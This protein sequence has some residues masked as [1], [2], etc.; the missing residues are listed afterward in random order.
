[1]DRDALTFLTQCGGRNAVARVF[2]AGFRTMDDIDK[3]RDLF[4]TLL[5]PA[6]AG[7]VLA[8]L[9]RQKSCAASASSSR[10][11]GG[12]EAADAAQ[13]HRRG[14]GGD[15]SERGQDPVEVSLRDWETALQAKL[16]QAALNHA[17][18][19][20]GPAF[21]GPGQAPSGQRRPGRMLRGSSWRVNARNEADQV[22][23]LKQHLAACRSGLKAHRRYTA[24]LGERHTSTCRGGNPVALAELNKQ[25][26]G[27]REYTMQVLRYLAVECGCHPG[28][29]EPGD[30]EETEEA[31]DDDEPL[32]DDAG[33][34]QKLRSAARRPAGSRTTTASDDAVQKSGG[35]SDAAA[36]AAMDPDVRKAAEKMFRDIDFNGNGI[37]SLA[38]VDKYIVTKHPTLNKK[39]AMMRAFHYVDRNKSGWLSGT[40]FLRFWAVFVPIVQL[41]AVFEAA[42]TDSDRRWSSAEFVALVRQQPALLVS[43]VAVRDAV[44]LGVGGSASESRPPKGSS[45]TVHAATDT[46]RPKPALDDVVALALQRAASSDVAA[47]ELFT[48]IDKNGGGQVL[49]DEVCSFVL[50]RRQRPLPPSTTVSASAREDVAAPQAKYTEEA[51]GQPTGSGGSSSVL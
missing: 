51:A 33:S 16:R 41:F 8:A 30:A 28:G 47:S 26:N 19:L 1:M 36:I 3:R 32:A 43:L 13:S 14:G 21:P 7:A 29:G 34:S 38:E 42:D 10:R 25:L 6:T 27:L 50:Q 23:R 2:Q 44:L 46:A 11:S 17:S 31:R 9:Q 15:E 20:L 18:S 45:V 4:V 48:L 35:V 5:S 22:D 24:L 37:V 12:G 49:F 40:E 39:P